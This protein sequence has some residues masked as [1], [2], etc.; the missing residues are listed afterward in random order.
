MELE[1]IVFDFD[2][3]LAHLNIDFS[4]MRRRV[5]SL[6]PAFDLDPNLM[7]GRYI[8]EGIEAGVQ[9]LK[10]R[11][12]ESALFEERAEEILLSLKRRPPRRAISCRGF[13]G[14]CRS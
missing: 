12:E 13:R 7:E 4:E 10:E 9:S 5:V 8:L 6:F 2:G 11:G 14:P 3:T 1:T